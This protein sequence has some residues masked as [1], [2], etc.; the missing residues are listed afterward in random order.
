M[1]PTEWVIHQLDFPGKLCRAAFAILAMFFTNL[2]SSA[3][4]GKSAPWQTHHHLQTHRTRDIHHQQWANYS[5][6][7]CQTNACANENLNP[8]ANFSLAILCEEQTW[9]VNWR[10]KLITIS[11]LIKS[12]NKASLSFAKNTNRK[13][14]PT[15]KQNKKNNTWSTVTH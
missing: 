15:N 6:F 11:L 9:W 5:R 8:S 3:H 10:N 4:S 13:I 12:G 1:G 14:T 7:H 2:I